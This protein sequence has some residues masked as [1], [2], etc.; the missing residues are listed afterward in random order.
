M[1]EPLTESAIQ[2]ALS[3]LPDWSF[4]DNA[5]CKTYRFSGFREAMAFLN[6]VACEAEELNHHP[7]WRNVYNRVEVRLCTHDAGD[8]VTSRDVELAKRMD[9]CLGS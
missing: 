4:R 9:C 7:D 3:G 5:L 2:S 8:R 6:R 1:P